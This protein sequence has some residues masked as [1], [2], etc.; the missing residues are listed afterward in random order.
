V[1]FRE[2]LI[3]ILAQIHEASIH[4]PIDR[5]IHFGREQSWVQAARPQLQMAVNPPSGGDLDRRVTI[6]ETQLQTLLPTLATKTDIVELRGQFGESRVEGRSGYE[7]L[8][9]AK[10]QLRKDMNAGFENLRAADDQLRKA[11][12]RTVKELSLPVWQLR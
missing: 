10:D 12:R 6:L 5:A 11:L 9:V 1:K 3:H 4:I 2:A 8:W 7:K